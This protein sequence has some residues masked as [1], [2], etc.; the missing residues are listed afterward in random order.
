LGDIHVF[1]SAAANYLP[2]VRLLFESIRK[3]HPE[4][5]LHLAL[6]D[7]ARP[8]IDLPQESVDEIIAI[9]ELDIPSWR[10]WAFCHTIVE[11]STAIKPFALRHILQH[12]DC[13]AVLYFDPDMVLFS[14]IDDILEALEGS[15]I[16]L[17]PHQTCPES[18]LD[19]IIDNE[20]SSLKHGIYN[21]GFI[22]VKNH[23]EAL[24]F[25]DWWSAR[26]YHFCRA[27]IPMGLFT[28]QRWIDLVP[29]FFDGVGIIKSPRH[30]VATWNLTT[31]TLTGSNN[32]G[33]QVDGTPLG[34]YHFTG[35][36]SGAHHVMMEKYSKSNRSAKGLLD[37]YKK[38]LRIVEK[39]SDNDNGWFFDSF[40]N[41]VDI[42]PAQRIVYRERRDLQI[43][44]PN[45]FDSNQDNCFLN[46]WNTQ[47]KI[48]YPLLFDP[49]SYSKG[50]QV[51]NSS[52]TPGYGSESAPPGWS[53]LV[54]HLAGA[55]KHKQYRKLLV[56]K[57]RSTIE[58]EGL[59]GI[60]RKIR[61]W[62]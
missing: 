51:I 24:R 56:E 52:L 34:F 39:Q 19:A 47:G 41:G 54:G 50:L 37:W 58:T 17:T 48:E 5:I 9:S 43:A 20:I 49:E 42:D 35:F 36:D 16:V 44:F 62:N 25:T 40:S 29:A 8:N 6:A 55:I 33:Y 14:R 59:S 23:A 61:I 7:Q 12:T 27:N 11:L 30:N 45:P 53:G 1:T 15:N 18:S 22:G 60:V 26:V 38:Q 4:F 28:D 31:R 2:K 46:W 32:E 10:A 21:L 13:K 57:L 3:Y